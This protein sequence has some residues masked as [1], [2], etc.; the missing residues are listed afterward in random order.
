MKFTFKQSS[1]ISYLSGA[2]LWVTISKKVSHVPHAYVYKRSPSWHCNWMTFMFIQLKL[3][4]TW[5]VP[6]LLIWTLHNNYTNRIME[7]KNMNS[8]SYT[9][10]WRHRDHDGLSNHQPH[11][12]LI[13]GLFGRRSKKTSK[14]RVTGL[15]AGKSP[16]TGEIPAQMASNAENVS[17]LWRH[18]V[19]AFGFPSI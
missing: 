10:H 3:T 8:R 19:V 5:S 1:S 4:K 11:D 14:L 2:M 18:R 7:L 12:C 15:C 17:I 16:G 6:T 9:L 13:N